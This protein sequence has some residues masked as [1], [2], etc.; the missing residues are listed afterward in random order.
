MR[1]H[2]SRWTSHRG[3]AQASAHRSAKEGGGAGAAI[4]IIRKACGDRTFDSATV[5]LPN[6]DPEAAARGPVPG[7][8]ET[9]YSREARGA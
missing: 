1:R 6:A 9:T 5:P 4:W 8:E 3:T 2:G 7:V